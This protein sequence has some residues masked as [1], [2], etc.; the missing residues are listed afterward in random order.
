MLRKLGAIW[1]WVMLVGMTCF[2][3]WVGVK[4]IP[5]IDGLLLQF[6]VGLALVSSWMTF[7]RDLVKE[8]F[9]EDL[10]AESGAA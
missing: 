2:D 4:A 8:R 9:G 5:Q 1:F 3:I 6:C 7:V 10:D